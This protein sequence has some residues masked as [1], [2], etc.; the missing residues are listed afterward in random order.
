MMKEEVIPEVGMGAT[1]HV[2]SDRYRVCR[3]YTI[4]E[5]ITPRKIVVQRD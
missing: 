2:G 5:V 4:V 3:P 1:E